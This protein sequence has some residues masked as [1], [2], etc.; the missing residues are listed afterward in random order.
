MEHL[1]SPSNNSMVPKEAPVTTITTT[2]FKNTQAA[3]AM[4]T[5]ALKEVAMELASAVDWVA[6]PMAHS[7]DSSETWAV[8]AVT[9]CLT[10]VATGD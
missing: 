7:A 9:R 10:L 1:S 4:A 2:P 3:A 8:Q 5:E 6:L